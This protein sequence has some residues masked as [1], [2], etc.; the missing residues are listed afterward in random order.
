MGASR[1]RNGVCRWE[2][3]AFLEEKPPGIRGVPH[4]EEALPGERRN[5]PGNLFLAVI[6][7]YP[8]FHDSNAHDAIIMG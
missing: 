2:P 8:L 7:N 4:E 5:H 3:A 6:G 1:L